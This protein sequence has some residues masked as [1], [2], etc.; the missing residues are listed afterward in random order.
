M[1]QA[2]SAHCSYFHIPCQVDKTFLWSSVLS[3]RT[4]LWKGVV[5]SLSLNCVLCHAERKMK[6]KMR[7]ESGGPMNPAT[8]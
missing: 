2:K 7:M 1:I 8:L 5:C 6:T 3:I 4:A